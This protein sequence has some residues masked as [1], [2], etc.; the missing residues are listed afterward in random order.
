MQPRKVVE[1][2]NASDAVVGERELFQGGACFQPGNTADSVVT[3]VEHAQ[4]RVVSGWRCRADAVPR[5][6]KCLNVSGQRA[7]EEKGK[8]SELW[9]AS[10]RKRTQRNQRHGSHLKVGNGKPAIKRQLS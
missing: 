8:V 1:A 5:Q 6:V 9:E 2:T 3:E 4:P 10:Q 7:E